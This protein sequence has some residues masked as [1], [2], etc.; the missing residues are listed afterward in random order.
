MPLLTRAS[1]AQ[2]RSRAHSGSS[3][4][5]P[6]IVALVQGEIFCFDVD[7]AEWRQPDVDSSA[8]HARGGRMGQVRVGLMGA[9]L[10]QRIY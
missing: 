9:S 8:L 5:F 4:S 2:Q 1:A 7:R 6:E 10:H 3:Q